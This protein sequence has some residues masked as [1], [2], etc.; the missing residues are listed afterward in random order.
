MDGYIHRSPFNFQP[1]RPVSRPSDQVGFSETFNQEHASPKNATTEYVRK[2][3]S[4]LRNKSPVRMEPTY[5]QAEIDQMTRLPQ[6]RDSG[7]MDESYVRMKKSC[8][9]IAAVLGIKDINGD[10]SQIRESVMGRGMDTISR[11]P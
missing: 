10:M 11:S 2:S 9:R 6:V 8:E 4:P 3:N 5:S 7:F 1:I